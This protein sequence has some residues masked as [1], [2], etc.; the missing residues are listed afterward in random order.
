MMALSIRLTGKSFGKTPVL[1]AIDLDI[2]TG[3]VA[4]LLGPSGCGKS[5]LLSLIAGLDD[6]YQGDITLDGDQAAMV[7]QAPRLLPWRTL[8]ENIALVPGAGGQKRARSLLERVGLSSSADQ[9][10]QKVSLGMQRRASLARALAVRPALILMDEPLVSLDA[11][12]AAS[13]RALITETLEE[14]GTTALIATHDRREALHLSDR[15]IALGGSP[16]TIVNDRL[17]PLTAEQRRD[18]ALVEALH[19]EWFGMAADA[20][21][22]SKAGTGI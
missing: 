9:F 19:A 2:P 11:E 15:I 3:Q 20:K 14:S 21:V 13:M 7:F 12:T 5:T 16:T 18:P 6:D 10:P 1:G 22:E 17:S 4:T 8:V